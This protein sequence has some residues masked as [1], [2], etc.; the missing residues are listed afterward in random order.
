M[1]HRRKSS[2]RDRVYQTF[3]D[4]NARGFYAVND[5]L[6]LATLASVLA[7]ILETVPSLE[8]YMSFFLVIEWV[9]VAL[10]SL[11]YVLRIF[12]NGRLAG[13]Y[14][15]SFFGI[16]DLI[17]ILPSFL[18]LSNFTFLKTAR[19]LRILRLLRMVRLAKLAKVPRKKGYDVE[20]TV[21]AFSISM[22]IYFAALLTGIILFGSLMYLAEG[23]RPEFE[24]IPL[25]MLWAVKVTIGGIPQYMPE[26]VWG[27]F[28]TIGSRFFGLLLFGLLIA[29]TGQ[30]FKKLLLGSR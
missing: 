8:K 17:A 6:A 22:Q 20:N 2:L 30:A 7:I 10:F 18:G 29:I 14:I 12:A 28:I 25:A 24:S 5:I 3:Y 1:F 27:E 15:F 11:E 9:A 13:K 26:T 16:I 19:T 4:P 23:Y 21:G